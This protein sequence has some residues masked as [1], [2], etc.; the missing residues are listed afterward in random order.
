MS[1]L[2]IT[3][4][5]RMYWHGTRSVL[6]SVSRTPLKSIA[7]CLSFLPSTSFRLFRTLFR[8]I[9]AHT[10]SP[11]RLATYILLWI[12]SVILLALTAYRIHFTQTITGRS[13]FYESI[14][15]ELLVSS[16]LCILW[17]PI[18]A[19]L[20]AS[21]PD[22]HRDGTKKGR[23]S[24]ILRIEAIVLFILWVMWLVG[25]AYTTVRWIL[26]IDIAFFGGRQCN[27][28][29]SLMAFAWIGFSLLTILFVLTLMHLLSA[30]QVDTSNS[31][32]DAKGRAYG[33]SPVQGMTEAPVRMP[34]PNP[35]VNNANANPT[36]L[37]AV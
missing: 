10:F 24:R 37:N 19:F 11:G 25:A 1:Y 26:L 27:T 28:L 30:S 31:A 2:V 34:T 20:I 3:L 9:M 15:V 17:V 16:I 22:Q 14:V 5:P 23:L 29:T 8:R 13:H 35:G 4:H 18:I 33:Q 36:T 12:V 32:V 21:E 6:L 7:L